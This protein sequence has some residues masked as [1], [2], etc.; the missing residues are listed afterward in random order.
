[1]MITKDTA[2]IRPH[3]QKNGVNTVARKLRF[4]IL[5]VLPDIQRPLKIFQKINNTIV[6]GMTDQ[7]V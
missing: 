3:F 5:E 7:G 6:M 2:P 1:M 4:L